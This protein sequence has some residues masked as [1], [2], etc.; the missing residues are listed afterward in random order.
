MNTKWNALGFYPGLVG[1][2][3]I[4][5]DPYY[6]IYEAEKLGYHSQIISAGRKINDSMAEFVGDNIIK[7]LIMAN[8]NVRDSKVLLL[9]LTFKE[10]CPDIRN[11]KVLEIVNRLK[12]YGVEPVICDPWA[13]VKEAEQAYGVKLQKVQDMKDVDCIV[14]T[15]AHDVYRNMDVRDYEKICKSD[16]RIIIDVKSV[17]NKKKFEDRGF[18]VW[19]L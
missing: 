3:C 5:V 19:R 17:L 16:N 7:Q 12:E 9:G 11:T 6:F 15:V 8:K 2:H 1:G 4:G 14:L 13:D 10:N 18:S